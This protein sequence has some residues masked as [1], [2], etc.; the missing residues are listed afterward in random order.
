MANLIT[1]DR[2]VASTNHYAKL[3][4]ICLQPRW[5]VCWSVFFLLLN[6]TALKAATNNDIAP[7]PQN[8]ISPSELIS[9][10]Q[11]I[12]E[13][14]DIFLQPNSNI[15]SN[16]P[17]LYY[18]IKPQILIAA[19]DNFTPRLRSQ[20]VPLNL[21]A[22]PD[23]LVPNQQVQPP[24][25]SAPTPSPAPPA[26]LAPTP[27]STPTPTT[28]PLPTVQ[29]P[30]SLPEANPSAT[31]QNAVLPSFS[32][33][34]L[35]INFRNDVD[36]FGRENRFIEPTAQFRL[37]NGNIVQLKTGFNYFKYPGLE[38]VSN[39]PLTLG[40]QTKINQVTLQ[41]GVG[42]D[43][44][45]RLPTAINFNTKVDVPV[46]NNITLSGVVEQGLYKFNAET[47]ENQ[48][49]T[50]RYGPNLYW[51]IDRNTSLFSLLRLGNYNDG[52]F[53]QQ[54]FS[55]LERKFGPFSIAANLFNWSYNEDYSEKSGYFSPPDF[56]V[57]TGEV[58]LES[59]IFDFL[60]CRVAASLGQ[61]RLRGE[62]SNANSYEGRC[63]GKISQN[64]DADF[65]YVFS[66]VQNQETGN[67]QYNNQSFTGVLRFKF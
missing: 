10:K 15:Q 33:D 26:Q 9:H 17:Q 19:P 11:Q 4:L 48:I 2:S 32:L 34:N 55:R 58:A 36:K 61:Q 14:Q 65:G 46:G 8:F 50:W 53:E 42:V 25:Q 30:A 57:F 59:E 60:R 22:A 13:I 63:T 18:Q 1:P 44:F 5:G 24:A 49:R 41:A 52:N 54:S 45:N 28:P 43:V 40:Y 16:S 38:D 6:G 29:P 47:L 12:A 67:S 66:N 39:I 56:L 62:F 21:I 20:E 3:L 7:I 35:Q 27:A 31:I 37:S 23:N 64:I 51:Q